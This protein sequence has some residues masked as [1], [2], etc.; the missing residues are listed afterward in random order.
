MKKMMLLLACALMGSVNMLAQD[1]YDTKHEISVSYGAGAISL[2]T[3]SF[4]A[5]LGGALVGE[6]T[7][8]SD[9]GPLAIEYFYHVSEKVGIGGVFVYSS[10]TDE[11][12]QSG[13]KVSEMNDKFFTLMPSVKFNW[14]RK[15]HFGMYS[16][17]AAGGTY[18]SAEYTRDGASESNKTTS[19]FH[20]NFQLSLLGAEF[21][22]GQFRGFA[23]LGVGEQG[24][25]LAGLR[26]KF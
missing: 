18:D 5:G 1:G 9:F 25:A 15:N 17:I 23:E 6:T 7:E 24:F 12:H 26:Y 11:F 22:S 10:A 8:E 3:T 2:I 20:F 13:S 21:G 4:G 14:L 19:E 16:K